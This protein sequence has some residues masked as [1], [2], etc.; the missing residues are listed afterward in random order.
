MKYELP[1]TTLLRQRRLELKLT[2]RQV[3]QA[4]CMSDAV[5]SAIEN[6]RRAA[7]P[8]IRARILQIIPFDDPATAFDPHGFANPIP[9]TET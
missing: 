8:K 7:W 1:P 6:R 9:T 2:I 4:G 3:A 5:L